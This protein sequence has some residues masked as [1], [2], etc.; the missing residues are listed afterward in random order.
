LDGR[1]SII[2]YILERQLL[3]LLGAYFVVAS[4]QIK[5]QL[6]SAKWLIMYSQ[7]YLSAKKK[8]WGEWQL[9]QLSDL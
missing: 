2:A 8:K 1:G 5:K 3:K 6:S 9:L 7:N 4:K